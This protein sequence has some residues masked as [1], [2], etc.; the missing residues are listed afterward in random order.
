MRRRA[1]IA[2][3][4]GAAAAWPLAAWVQQSAKM[5][6]VALLVMLTLFSATEKTVMGSDIDTRPQSHRDTAGTDSLTGSQRYLCSLTP[7]RRG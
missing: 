1:L 2:L 4:A 3:L 7:P 5:L 6:R